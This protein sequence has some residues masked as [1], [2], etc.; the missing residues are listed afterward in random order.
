VRWILPGQ[1]DAAIAGWFG[2]FPAG[3]DSREDTYLIHPVLRGLAVKIRAG[4][5]LEVKQYHG[6]PGILDA[7]GRAC[8]RIESWRKWSFPFGPL[9]PDNAGP[10]SWVVVHKR[11]RMSRF[12]LVGGQLMADAAD[13]ARGTEC[14]VE[15]TEVRLGGETWWS[16][17][18]EAT[19]P[20]DLLSSTLES[21]VA[22]MFAEAL[23]GDVE[24]DMNHCQSYA[25]WL[26]RHRVTAAIRPGRVRNLRRAEGRIRVCRMTSG[27]KGER[28]SHE[29]G[30]TMADLIAI[31]YPDL[32]TA[33]EAADVARRLGAGLIIQPDAIAVIVRDKD[34]S[35][36]VHTTYHMVGGG[37]IWA[38]SGVSVR[39]AVLH[40]GLR[41]GGGSRDGRADGQAGQDQHRQAVP[42]PGPRH[43]PAGHEEVSRADP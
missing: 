18:F 8:G 41:D 36:H 3:L 12:R 9:G 21:T 25:E 33:D 13:R 19:G 30:N 20:A 29:E 2:R 5:M 6:S 42:G 40:P 37:A 39:A 28:T 7:A 27:G 1:L 4:Q 23:P 16:L 22:L 34:G 11:R 43:A 14:G 38:C 17:G 26:S 31:G 15:L 35:Y 10:P 24:L 32:T